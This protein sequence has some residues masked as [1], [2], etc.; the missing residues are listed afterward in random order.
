MGRLAFDLGN[1]VARADA[2]PVG[3]RALERR[4][5]GQVALA[6]L[7]RDAETVVAPL[8]ALLKLGVL[9][10]GQEIR[11]RIERPQHAADRSVDEVFRSNL[12]HVLFFHQPE[13]VG[14]ATEKLGVTV[15]LSLRSGF[16]TGHR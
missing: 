6:H 12:G 10:L 7:H 5:D 15:Y 4:D 9:L 3:G 1:D 8:L 11:V 2:Q 16:R 13:H 14:I